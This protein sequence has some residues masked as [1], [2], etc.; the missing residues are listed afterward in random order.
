MSASKHND[1]YEEF[2]PLEVMPTLRLND[3][4]NNLDKATSSVVN[5]DALIPAREA[6][7]EVLQ[8]LLYKIQRSVKTLSLRYNNFSAFSIELIIDWIG[9]ND[10]IETLYIMGSGLDEK[11]KKRLEDAWRRNLTGHWFENSGF[12]MI[13]VSFETAQAQ[14]K[15]DEAAKKK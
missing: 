11:N 10:H 2:V 6:G 5:L 9:Q 4:A 8:T 12:T 15:Q 3:V 13:R 7:E 1:D 14:Q